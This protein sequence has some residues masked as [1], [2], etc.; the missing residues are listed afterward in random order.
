MLR[1]LKTLPLVLA[2]AAFGIFA[3]GCGTDH[4]QVRFVHA[5][6]DA[7]NLDITVDSKSVATNLAFGSVAPATGYLT[8]NAGNR[9]VQMFA[10][11][12]TTPALIDSNVPFSSQKEYTAIVSGFA[13]PPPNDTHLIAAIVLT[14][15]NSVPTSGNVKLRVV[16]AS[17]SGPA[18][19]DV[20]IVPQGT[21]ITGMTP[22]ISSLAY[23]QASAYQ[24]VAPASNQVIFTV[25]G[26]VNQTPIINQTYTLAAGQIRT[27]VTVNVQNGL[28]MSTTPL[29]LSDLN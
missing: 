18:D 21:D 28:T 7:L 11:G 16:H 12:T 27:L 9:T 4:S 8:V 25:A 19:V 14:D 1:L 29:E 20:Y 23:G 6:S 13:T 2:M 17:P 24:S 10:T 15:D 26:D 3:T 22:T 5:S